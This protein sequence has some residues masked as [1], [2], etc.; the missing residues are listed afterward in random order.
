[1]VGAVEKDC[2]NIGLKNSF[3]LN[4]KNTQRW[5][6]SPNFSFLLEKKNPDSS[7]TV[8]AGKLLPFSLISCVYSYAIVYTWL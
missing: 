5:S 8:T 3:F 2:R 7:L 6:K 1:M 4:K